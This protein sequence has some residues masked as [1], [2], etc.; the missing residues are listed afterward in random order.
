M[1]NDEADKV[2]KEL[3]DSL[4]NRYKNN[5]ESMKG[6]EFGFYYIQILYCHKI[7]LNRG[8]SYIHSPDWMKNKKAILS[9]EEI[10]NVFN[11]L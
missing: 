7:N 3:S 10:T 1:I 11:I 4:K 9:I 6:R 2:I 5:L 8:G